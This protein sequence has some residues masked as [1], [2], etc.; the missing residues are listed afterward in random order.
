MLTAEG[1]TGLREAALEGLGVSPLPG[2]LVADDLA[3]GRL[4]RL[5]PE[6]RAQGLP[7]QV[8]Y[9]VQ[10]GLPQRVRA[11]VDFIS[12]AVRELLARPCVCRKTE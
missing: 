1:V 11:L 6:W 8:V 4:V 12:E 10:K 9:P 5:L 7:A 2:W 3:S